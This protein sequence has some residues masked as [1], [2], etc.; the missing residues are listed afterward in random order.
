MRKPFALLFI[1]GVLAVPLL[2]QPLPAASGQPQA[3]QTKPL[4]PDAA[5]AEQLKKLFDVIG[6]Q[7]Q[8]QSLMTSLAGSMEQMIPSAA[9]LS[10]KQK[11]EMKALQTELFGKMMSP[12]FVSSYLDMM[13]PVY[14]LHFTKTDVDQ[15]IAFYSSPTGQKFVNEQPLIVQEIFP[16]ILPMM[17]Q[18]MQEV[19]KDSNFEQRLKD[20][21]TEDEK[22]ETKPK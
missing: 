2:A 12:E 19:M 17:Q 16:M 14:Q 5:S 9:Q 10:E 6:I 3:A 1:A 15:I 21:F 13:V 20:I 11:A 7:K 8:M 4:P 22:T 18:H